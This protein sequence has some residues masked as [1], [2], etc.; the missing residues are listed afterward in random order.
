MYS[1]GDVIRL[2]ITLRNGYNRTRT[3]GG[4]KLHVRIYNTTLRAY[5]P[6]HVIDHNNG[7]YT[8]FVRTFW[9]GGQTISVY[10]SYRRETVRALYFIRRKVNTSM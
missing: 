9:P 4:D 7:T 10:L 5:A 6:G 1:V 3:R 2:S 8:V